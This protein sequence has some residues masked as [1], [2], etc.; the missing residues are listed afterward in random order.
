MEESIFS[1]HEWLARNGAEADKYPGKWIAVIEG[2]ILGVS[3]SLKTLLNLEEVKKV[4]HPLITKVPTPDE[5]H[6]IL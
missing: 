1:A 3:D 2:K 6:S 4:K 5:I